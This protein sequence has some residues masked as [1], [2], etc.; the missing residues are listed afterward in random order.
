MRKWKVVI[1]GAGGR[2]FHN[3]NQF[4]RDRAEC[5]VVA[6]TATQIPHISDRRYPASL[7]GPQ[8]PEGIPIVP[9][10]HL[11]RLLKEH[12][13]DEVVFAYSDVSHE[14]VMHRASWV[15]SLGADFRLMG[16]KSTMIQGRL[17]VVAVTAVRTGSG[18]SPTT[19]RVCSVLR[20]MGKRVVAVRHPMPYGDLAKQRTQRFE[21][22]EDLDREE[23][24]IEEREE[25]EPHIQSGTVVYA[26]VH[27]A[28]ILRRAE[29]EADVVVWDGGNNDTSFYAPDFCIVVVD[30]LRPGHETR[31]HPGEVNVRSADAIVINKI[32]SAEPEAV[33]A[34]EKSVRALNPKAIVIKADSPITVDHPELLRGKRALVI[35]D[36]PTVTHG[37]MKYGAG[38][39]AAKRHGASAIVDPRPYA[40]GEIAD[41]FR[42][43]PEIGALLPAMGYGANQIR[44]LED[45]IAKTDCDVVVIATPIDLR[46]LVNI[47]QPN[48]RVQYELQ[49]IGAPSLDGVLREFLERVPASSR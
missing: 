24:T 37:E 41:T 26:G 17:P 33:A 3:F 14:Y 22:M 29:S 36:G 2:D 12:D 8:Y 45:T 28:E 43:Y 1:M 6:F 38:V 47:R 31:Y 49:E 30:P 44:D 25:Y 40:T 48:V 4:Y 46:R 34:V 23:C 39:V 10:D 42:K 9:E 5:E 18:K 16:S 13:V 21:K 7:A 11:P 19:R 20:S 15:L 27:Y 35:E 32:D